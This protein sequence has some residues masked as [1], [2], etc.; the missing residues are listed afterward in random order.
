MSL[1]VTGLLGLI[2]LILIVYAIVKIIGSP[3][4]TG[5]KVIWIVIVLLL[6]VLG[7]ILWFL[8]GPS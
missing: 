4:G 5:S 1:E 6:P 8:F 2:H 3:S 7:L